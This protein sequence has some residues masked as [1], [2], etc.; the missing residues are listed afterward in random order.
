[1]TDKE[2][3]QEL[4]DA[5]REK[6]SDITEICEHFLRTG[7]LREDWIGSRFVK[8]KIPKLSIEVEYDTLTTEI[9]YHTPGE[10]WQQCIDHDYTD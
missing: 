10:Y 1:M 4:A 6:R 2:F 7:K 9:A 8:A 5:C 3:I